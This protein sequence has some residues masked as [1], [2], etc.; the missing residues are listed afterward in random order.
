MTNGDKSKT[1]DIYRMPDKRIDEAKMNLR[2]LESK[3]PAG[4]R[5]DVLVSKIRDDEP[6]TVTAR[7]AT[8]EVVVVN[9]EQ[10]LKAITNKTGA[11]NPFKAAMYFTV[12]DA[13]KR[14][15]PDAI[16]GDDGEHYKLNDLEKT[17]EFGSSKGSGLG[18][19]DTRYVESISCVFLAWRQLKRQDLTL[20]DYDDIMSLSVDSF[21]EFLGMYTRLDEKLALDRSDIARYWDKWKHSFT[22]IPNFLYYPGIIHSGF[23]NE[24]LLDQGRLYRFCQL[25]CTGGAVA[26]LRATFRDRH[27]GINFAKWNPSDIFAVDVSAEAEIEARLLACKSNSLLNDIVDKSF[28]T[29]Q[30]VGVSLKKIKSESDIRIIVNKITRPPRYKM[31]TVRVSRLPLAT[32]GLEIV[33]DRKSREFGH[34]SEVMVVRSRGGGKLQNISAEVRGKTAKHGNMSLT[35]INKILDFYGLEKVPS[36]AARTEE[37]YRQSIEEWSEAD[38][39]REILAINKKIL[40]YYGT[41]IEPRVLALEVDRV[42]LLSKYQALFLAWVIMDAENYLSDREGYT[43]ADRVVEDMF[44][45]ALSIN[46]T[47][48]K[49]SGRTPRYARIVE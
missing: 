29:R 22:Y 23:K 16:L 20:E 5:G 11:Y 40:H 46:I 4:L 45:F 41:P 9:K 47:P 32:I 27:P 42:R 7:G 49:D 13:H 2:E 25:S 44:H 18:S 35:Q 1:H 37:H 15:R 19:V 33:A 26:A 36:V 31:S 17:A 34:G 8:K 28:E 38:I 39:K 21:Q 14:Y 43:L 10:V 24:N 48:G 6:I 3:S 12:P 30:M